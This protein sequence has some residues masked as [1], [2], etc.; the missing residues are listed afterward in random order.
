[1]E[2]Q[3]I[4]VTNEQIER[5]LKHLAKTGREAVCFCFGRSVCGQPLWGLRIGNPHKQTLLAGAFHGL[6][7]ITSLILLKFANELLQRSAQNAD[8][9]DRCPYP[10]PGLLEK[11]GVT[12]IPL[13]NPDGVM[14]ANG[15]LCPKGLWGKRLLE[16]DFD[17]AR[18]QANARG[19][20]L[21]HNF[22]AAWLACRDAERAAHI[23]G[24]GPTKYGGRK[25]HSEPEVKALVKLCQKMQFE[26]VV[27]FHSQ[28]EE[29]YAGHVGSENDL[30]A[31]YGRQLAALCGYTLCEPAPSAAHGGFKDW[32]CEVTGNPGCTVEVGLGVNP[33]PLCAW[34][35]I[36]EKLEKMLF[37]SFV[38]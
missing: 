33:L 16:M 12:I 17:P 5:Y 21:N 23:T 36:Y 19:V 30:A 4:P 27:A 35:E 32:F 22:D 34:Q 10:L 15:T 20:D 28:G 7:S 26:K 38:L 18:W 37:C 13:M 25:P 31:Q 24:P 14:L 9:D 1:M 3:A 29:I 6:E 8:A 2:I 11:R